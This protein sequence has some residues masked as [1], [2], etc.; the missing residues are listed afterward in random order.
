MKGL[1]NCKLQ[2]KRSQ[3][4]ATYITTTSY[5]Y[6][7][8]NKLTTKKRARTHIHT[9]KRTRAHTHTHT[10]TRARVCTLTHSH[11]LS[12]THTHTHKHH[13]RTSRTPLHAPTPQVYQL[14]YH[15]YSTIQTHLLAVNMSTPSMIMNTIVAIL[16]VVTE[17]FL[18]KYIRGN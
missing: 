2:I 14:T 8:S 11:A 4:L 5:L 17:W 12:R 18:Y 13:M 3:T 7:N 16:R 1:P 6:K 9:K 15:Y 10:H